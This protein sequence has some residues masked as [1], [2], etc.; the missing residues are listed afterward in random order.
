MLCPVQNKH[1]SETF[2]LIDKG[3]GKE[4]KY[5]LGGQIKAHNWSPKVFWRLINISMVNAFVLYNALAEEHNPDSKPLD[6]KQAIKEA[7]HAFCQRGESMRRQKAE[8][9]SWIR[10]LSVVHSAGT[11]RKIRTDKNGTVSKL[12]EQTE[13]VCRKGESYLQ[14]QQRKSLGGYI[15][16][17]LVTFVAIVYSNAAQT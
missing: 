15:K 9:P 11:G 2:H 12:N 16:V 8:H 17:L 4:V 1:Y 5:D 10:D 14:V 6:M 13:P 3:N 7:T